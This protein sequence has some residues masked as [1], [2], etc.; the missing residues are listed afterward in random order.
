VG[1]QPRI[2]LW[3]DTFK[4]IK[5]MPLVG[6]GPETFRLAFMPYKSMDLARLEKNTNFDNPHNNYLYLWATTGALG[7]GAYLYLLF[8]CFH[9][10]IRKIRK[11]DNLSARTVYLGL[12][13]T[14]A[15][16]GV[17]MLTGFDTTPTI[18]CFYAVVALLAAGERL[19]AKGSSPKD[20]RRST[21]PLIIGFAIIAGLVTY[22]SVRIVKA[23]HRALL[24]MEKANEGSQ[25]AF[26]ESRTLLQQAINL[27][28]RESFYPLQ[29]GVV[30]LMAG[31]QGQDTGRE[32]RESIYWAKR[33]L[34]HGWAPENS[35][36]LISTSYLNLETWE[37]AEQACRQGL[38]LDPY[39]VPLKYNLAKALMSLGR[40]EEALKEVEEILLV[41]DQYQEAKKL[42]KQLAR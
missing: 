5:E 36:N 6:S 41:D 29:R 32:F 34:V 35:W 10:G 31:V 42:K 11:G 25:A 38:A 14:L 20:I 1:E 7:L 17:S 9:K 39:N 23:D 8:C 22:D 4:V 19:G 27:L 24:G 2:Y 15:A 18:F 3:R 21:M 16:Y 40:S 12:L 33:S 26:D 13:T 37:E 28:P 30:S